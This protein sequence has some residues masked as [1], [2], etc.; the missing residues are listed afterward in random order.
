MYESVALITFSSLRSLDI[1]FAAFLLQALEFAAG[2]YNADSET[3]SG[4]RFPV[5]D[6]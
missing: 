2:Q 5:G 6:I 3:D 4:L 1:E